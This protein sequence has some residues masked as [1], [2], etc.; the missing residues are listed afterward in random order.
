ARQVPALVRVEHDG[1]VVADRLPDDAYAL[2]VG[3]GWQT[4]DLHL[5]RAIA[6]LEVHRSLTP[7]IV[8]ALAVAVVEAGD[9]GGHARAERPAEELVDGPLRG[10]AHEVPEGDID[11]ADGGH[12]LPALAREGRDAPHARVGQGEQILPDPLDAG[13]ILADDERCYALEDLADAAHRLRTAL[14]QERTVRLANPDEAGICRE[15]HD[16]LAHAADGR[17]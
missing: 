6:V 2:G 12:E 5:H 16:E 4:R 8:R 1:D 11:G 3:L 13:R 9:V 17:G 14:G 10:L 15:L 7:E